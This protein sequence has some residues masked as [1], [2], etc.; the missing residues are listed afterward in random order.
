MIE[1]MSYILPNTP[2]KICFWLRYWLDDLYTFVFQNNLYVYDVKEVCLK[3]HILCWLA[4]RAAAVPKERQNVC[5]A[6][7]VNP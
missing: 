3:G 2:L 1:Q 4:P 6:T 7:L 5:K